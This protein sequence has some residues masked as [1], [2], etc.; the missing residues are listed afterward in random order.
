MSRWWR[1]TK[2]AV[3]VIAEAVA[4]VIAEVVAEVTAAA[5]ATKKIGG[6]GSGSKCGGVSVSPYC[7]P[8]PR[9]RSM[10]AALFASNA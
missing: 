6:I 9:L 2:A 8:V 3:E 7:V 1:E 5:A 4:E 10:Q